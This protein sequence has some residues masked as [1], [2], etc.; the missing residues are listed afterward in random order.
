MAYNA[1]TDRRLQSSDYENWFVNNYIRVF[2][3]LTSKYGTDREK[4]LTAVLGSKDVFV[5]NLK[6]THPRCIP[7][8][9][10]HMRLQGHITKIREEL[11]SQIQPSLFRPSTDIKYI[12][13]AGYMMAGKTT[14]ANIFC[15]EAH[16]RELDATMLSFSDPLKRMMIDYFGFTEDDLYTQEG[17]TKVNPLWDMT[18]RECLQKMGTEAIRNGFHPDAWVIM[19]RLQTI[20]KKGIF[21]FDDVRFDNEVEFIKSNGIVIRIDRP[22][23][24]LPPE[25]A[26]E[27]FIKD[28]DFVIV[29]CD[30][31]EAFKDKV[32]T[33]VADIYRGSI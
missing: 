2:D 17:K 7:L 25:H 33:L 5:A 11:Y 8:L 6:A 19:A 4:A 15:D 29:N 1:D 9:V 20:G 3:R 12:G 18:N 10:A 23:M 16:S 13:F 22:G 26:S 21:I 27:Q 28:P 24:P 32:A 14:A 30:T 31:L